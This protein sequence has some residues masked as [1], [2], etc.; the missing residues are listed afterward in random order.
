MLDL[1]PFLVLYLTALPLVFAAFWGW[2]ILSSWLTFL[3]SFI[4]GALRSI[5]TVPAVW[6]DRRN[7]EYINVLHRKQPQRMTTRIFD[8]QRTYMQFIY[9]VLYFKYTLNTHDNY[10]MYFTFFSNM[11]KSGYGSFF[12]RSQKLT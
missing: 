2:S 11:L 5:F 4:S 12:W 10:W 1:T 9:V 7:V 3:F 6:F 8:L